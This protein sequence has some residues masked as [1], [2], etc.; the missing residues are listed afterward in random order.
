MN[1]ND[2]KD[3][4]S[5]RAKINLETSRMTWKELLRFFAAGSIIVV[6]D[7]A[8]LVE[9][10]ACIADDDKESVVKWMAEGVIGKVSDAQAEAWLKADAA[11][12]TAIVK[13]W[14]LVQEKKDKAGMH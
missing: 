1:V 4:A 14:I 6:S 3:R 10:A 5:L 11:L 12:W 13:P 2:E 7:A 8:D 9:V